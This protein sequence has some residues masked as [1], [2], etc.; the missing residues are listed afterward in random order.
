MPLDLSGRWH[1]ASMPSSSSVNRREVIQERRADM[2]MTDVAGEYCAVKVVFFGELTAIGLYDSVLFY[3]GQS[4]GAVFRK[5]NKKGASTTRRYV[6]VCLRLYEFGGGMLGL[7][8]HHVCALFALCC[9]SIGSGIGSRTAYAAHDLV[10][11]V[12]AQ[13]CVDEDTVGL[14]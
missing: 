6:G 7:S 14:S 3:C 8:C 10:G 13:S 11:N 1:E 5:G 4:D 9:G 2:M 12:F